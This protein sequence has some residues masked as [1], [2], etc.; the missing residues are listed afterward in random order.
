M[1]LLP[2]LLLVSCI[3]PR[4]GLEAGEC[5]DYLDN[6]GNGLMDCEE[7]ICR[8]GPACK[9]SDA[10]A[11]ADGDADAEIRSGPVVV[12]V[13]DVHGWVVEH[14][15]QRSI[16]PGQVRVVQVPDGGADHGLNPQ[17]LDGEPHPRQGQHHGG[18]VD[19]HFRPLETEG[20]NPVHFAVF[21]PVVQLVK[22]PEN[23]EPVEQVVN[24]PL[25]K[26]Q[27]HNGHA[28]LEPQRPVPGSAPP[29]STQKR[30][31]RL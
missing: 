24:A 10:D 4:E 5:N 25:Q 30:A 8:E 1:R 11:D 3:S 21:H 2:V 22:A 13:P 20:H 29:G 16:G 12:V 31:A 7:P 9:E 17:G 28:G 18:L 27:H 6:D 14:V 23:G 19:H 26:V 15:A